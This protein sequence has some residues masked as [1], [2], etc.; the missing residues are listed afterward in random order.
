M[1]IETLTIV[2]IWIFIS[3]GAWAVLKGFFKL[4]SYVV[5]YIILYWVRS[6]KE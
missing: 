4:M 1:S 3:I 5:A 2:F 6:K